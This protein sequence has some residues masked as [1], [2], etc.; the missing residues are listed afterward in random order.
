MRWYHN[1]GQWETMNLI[2]VALS[3]SMLPLIAC[4]W[5]LGCLI[6][7]LPFQLAS[8]ILKQYVK[9]HWSYQPDD[10]SELSSSLDQRINQTIPGE[11]TKVGIRQ[12]LLRGLGDPLSKIRATVVCEIL[13]FDKLNHSLLFLIP[14]GICY[15]CYCPDR[16]ARKL[17]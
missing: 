15:I 9:N 17:A 12:T 7:C 2:D 10:F 1:Y 3:N 8:V 13:F 11:P 4:N 6:N 16:L 14:L 5:C